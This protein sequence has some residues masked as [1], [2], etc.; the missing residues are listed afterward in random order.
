MV[1]GGGQLDVVEVDAPGARQIQVF[2]R[3]GE[4]PDGVFPPEFGELRARRAQSL[5]EFGSGRLADRYGARRTLTVSIAVTA[6]V[7]LALGFAGTAAEVFP[8]MLVGGAACWSINA[9]LNHRLTGLDGVQ[10]PVVISLNSSGSYLWQAL[11]AVIGG[12]LLAHHIGVSA[13]CVI[14]AAVAFV[15]LILHLATVGHSAT[16]GESDR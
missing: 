14:A 13:L 16:V 6:L 8:L 15:A 5:D 11:G 12:V 4:P 10:P 7:L 1:I 2:A 3:G 9:P